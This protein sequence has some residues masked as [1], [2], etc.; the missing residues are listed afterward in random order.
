[1]FSKQVKR[2]IWATLTVMLM[3]TLATLACGQSTTEGLAEAPRR[4]QTQSSLNQQQPPQALLNQLQH[5]RKKHNLR[6]PSHR[7]PPPIHSHR[8]P[9]RRQPTRLSQLAHLGQRTPIHPPRPQFPRHGPQGLQRPVSISG[10]VP[11]HTTT[12]SVSFKAA[13]LSRFDTRQAT[14]SGTR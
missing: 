4:S 5:L 6:Q 3:L 9:R 13:T 10:E 8:L 2:S 14:V 12:R 7:Q 11:A 1:M